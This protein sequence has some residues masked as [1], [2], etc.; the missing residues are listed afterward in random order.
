MLDFPD[1]LGHP[2]LPAHEGFPV[3]LG[4]SASR[5]FCSLSFLFHEDSHPFRDT[6]DFTHARKTCASVAL[7]H[8]PCVSAVFCLTPVV[9]PFLAPPRIL[10][11]CIP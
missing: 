1:G 2:L 9:Q 5:A 10:A 3:C 6:A 4:F 8:R 11:F 7:G